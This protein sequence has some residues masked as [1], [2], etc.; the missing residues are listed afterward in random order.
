MGYFYV[1]RALEA[2]DEAR[3]NRPLVIPT[4]FAANLLEGIDDLSGD[5][6]AVAAILDCAPEAVVETARRWR[7]ALEHY[8]DDDTW[9]PIP[10]YRKG[11]PMDWYNPSAVNSPDNGAQVARQALGQDGG[12]GE[13]D[14]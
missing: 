7:E 6:V 3:S 9:T 11:D 1:R 14:G 2:R 5:V 13:R 8:A 10:P 12:E 4:D